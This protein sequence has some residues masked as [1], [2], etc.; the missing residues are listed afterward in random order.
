M[1]TAA[2]QPDPFARV[3]SLAAR[4]ALLGLHDD[5]PRVPE[6]DNSHADNSHAA[7]NGHADAVAAESLAAQNVE[8]RA[9]FADALEMRP[10]EDVPSVAVATQSAASESLGGR[11]KS[12]ARW[13]TIGTI[14][15]QVLS[16]VLSVASTRLLDKS[17]FGLFGAATSVSGALPVLTNI[18]LSDAMIAQKFESQRELENQLNTIWTAELLRRLLMSVAL[19]LLA[20]PTA[21]FYKRDQLAGIMALL[22]LAPLL[23]GFNTPGLLLLR[24]E[25]QFQR[26]F[27]FNATLSVLST[28]VPILLA[29]RLHSVWAL[30]W[31]A[32][33]GEACAAGLSYVFHPFRPRLA[34]DPVAFKRAFSFGKNTFV[35][36]LMAYVTTNADNMFVMRYWGEAI[37]APYLIAYKIANLPGSALSGVTSGVMF[38][39]Y[40]E[41]AR[42]GETERLGNTVVRVFAV[43]SALLVL[44]LGPVA[45]LS[46]DALQTIYGALYVEAAPALQILSIVGFMRGLLF[47]I[48]PLMLGMNKPHLEARSKVCEA[49]L[50][51]CILG[52]MVARYGV[53]GAS[54]A[55][56]IT[57][58][59]SCALRFS[60]ARA[61]LPNAFARVPRVI[62]ETLA[63]GVAAGAVMLGVLTLLAR[64]GV[65]APALRFIGG[66]LFYCAGTLA[67]LWFVRPSLRQEMREVLKR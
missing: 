60:F 24:R 25:V 45:L 34:F 10:P 41:I 7:D 58:A 31:G 4:R 66:S 46:R 5:F 40:A 37:L 51:V 12:G 39:V 43:F 62:L 30:V 21:L 52:P 14:L 67:L 16:L 17:A 29:W 6:R 64:V 61:A 23:G 50:F 54:W 53:I 11:A 63:C 44:A 26:V 9:F 2:P 20:Y 22:A 56:V 59:L 27:Y 42:E 3:S 48:T 55:G 33:L 47:L 35:I 32:L 13:T 36:G 8:E 65:H 18:G 19:L 15:G 1:P 49:I 38:P 28:I 57:Y